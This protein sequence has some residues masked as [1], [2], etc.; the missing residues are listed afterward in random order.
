MCGFDAWCWVLC[1]SLEERVNI[2]GAH[3]LLLTEIRHIRYL[4]LDRARIL[5]RMCIV[6]ILEIFSVQRVPSTANCR[7]I[8]S[9]VHFD[10]RTFSRLPREYTARSRLR[11]IMVT[12]THTHARTHKHTHRPTFSYS[13]ELSSYNQVNRNVH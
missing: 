5:T 1:A 7:N 6:L 9:A 8:I 13:L 11:A 3:V 12:H 4:S 10:I 2:N